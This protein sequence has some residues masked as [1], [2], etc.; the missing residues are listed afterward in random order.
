M[1][2]IFQINRIHFKEI[3]SHADYDFTGHAFETIQ[4]KRHAQFPSK[5]IFSNSDIGVNVTQYIH[6]ITQSYAS[7]RPNPGNQSP[8]EFVE[9]AVFCVPLSDGISITRLKRRHEGALKLL[10][11]LILNELKV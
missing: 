7:I 3:H 2:L 8:G 11:I 4:S 10:N 9:F 6:F 1:K 5:V